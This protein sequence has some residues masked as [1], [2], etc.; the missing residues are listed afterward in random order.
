M[1]QEYVEIRRKENMIAKIKSALWIASIR[2]DTAENGIHAT[3]DKLE[4]MKKKMKENI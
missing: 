2:I 4:Y 1:K 3:E